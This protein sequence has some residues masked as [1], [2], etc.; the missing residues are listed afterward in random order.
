MMKT[1]KKLLSLLLAALLLASCASAAFGAEAVR[2]CPEIYV[3][4]FMGTSIYADKDDPNSDVIWPPDMNGILTDVKAAL[5]S[6]LTSLL[7]RDWKGFGDT[8]LDLVDPYFTPVF[9]GEGAEPVN[10]TG[11][12]YYPLYYVAPDSEL[13]FFYDWREDPFKTAADLNDFINE[14]CERAGVSQVNI[15][16]HS[17]GGVVFITYLT[18]YGNEKIR[19]AVLDSTAIYGEAYTGDLMKGELILDAQALE[20]YL[21][22][23]FDGSEYSE[24]LQEVLRSARVIGLTNALVQLGDE[25]IAN[26]GERVQRELLMPMFTNW[27]SIWAMIPDEDVDAAMHYVFDELCADQDR[28]VLRAKVEAYNEKIRPYKTET[29]KALNESANVYVLVRTGFSSLPLTP[30]CRNLSDGTVDT[31]YSSFGATTADFGKTLPA[32]VI[33]S[34]DPAYISPEKDIDASTCLFP[35]QTWF[36]RGAKHSPSYPAINAFITQ[37]LNEPTQQTVNTVDGFPRFLA[38]ESKD[39]ALHRDTSSAPD[40]PVSGIRKAQSIID[41]LRAVWEQLRKLLDMLLQWI[42]N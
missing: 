4:G 20:D 32:D 28:S 33:A 24:L 6:L 1:A 35:E 31:K 29:L 2:T 36:M 39:G 37:L 25:L 9:Y 41:R 27:L 40:A 16:A 15:H 21:N 14:V 38:I 19:G 42:K 13:T 34:R 8:A 30:S 11:A 5:P 3:H 18:L 23:A 17:Y 12:G 26:Q 10:N 7:L 22:Y